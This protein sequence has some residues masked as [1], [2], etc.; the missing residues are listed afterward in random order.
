[1]S[2]EEPTDLELGAGALGPWESAEALPFAGEALRQ[3]SAELTVLQS[4]LCGDHGGPLDDK[5]VA[6]AISGLAHRAEAA[7][8]MVY[9]LSRRTKDGGA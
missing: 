4:A 8:E 7:A 3:L 1:V 6:R 9:R 5:L 2:T